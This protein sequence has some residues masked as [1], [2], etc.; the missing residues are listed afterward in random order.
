MRPG[1]PD[2]PAAAGGAVL[3]LRGLA[4]GYGARPVLEAVDLTIPPGEFLAVIGPNGGGKSTLLKLIL[5]LLTPRQGHI[6][7]LGLPPARARGRV[8]YCPQ[9]AAFRRDFPLAV[10]DVVLQGRL[11]LPGTRWRWRA[12]DRRAVA[13]ALERVGLGGFDQRPLMALSGGQ[14]QRVLVA[15]ALVTEPALLLLDEPAAHLDEQ[16]ADA[17]IELLGGLAGPTT[18]VMVTHDLSCITERLNRVI[19]VNRRV[20]CHRPAE[21]DAAVIDR[22]FRHPAR[23][24]GPACRAPQPPPPD[25]APAA[26]SP[27]C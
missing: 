4:F 17:L 8:G 24:A 14:L 10:V 19:C 1:L 3:T 7:V 20:W 25:T 27:P 2:A 5:G 6:E 18:I 26:G 16:A 23:G 22:L 15:R 12:E 13:A 21:V 9:H 11:G